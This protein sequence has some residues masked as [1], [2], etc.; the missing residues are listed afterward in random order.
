MHLAIAD[1]SPLRDVTFAGSLGVSRNVFS[2]PVTRD[3]GGCYSIPSSHPLLCD[4]DETREA[5]IKDFVHAR[6]V[7]LVGLAGPE[8]FD[9]PPSTDLNYS[10]KGA[11][12][13]ISMAVPYHVGAIYD[14]LAKR[15][16]APHNLD[17]FLKYQRI[18]RLEKDL[19][20]FLVERGFRARPLPMSCDYR[21][22]PVR[23]FAQARL[24]AAPGRDS[25]G[26]RR[27]WLVGQRQDEGIRCRRPPGWSDHRRGAGERP[28]HSHQLLHRWRLC[29]VQALRHVL[30]SPHVRRQRGR[31][32]LPQ[33][34]SA[35]ARPPPQHRLLQYFLL[36]AAQPERGPQV[37]QLGTALDRGVGG[38]PA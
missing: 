37:Q 21:R 18:M 20:D 16:P 36:R 5:D 14:F 23:L 15:S 38:A 19:G 28:A 8:R 34:R 7:E 9:G 35:P 2:S 12:S 3:P 13:V 24:L 4:V 17:Q 31:V 27:P 10:M 26:H 11:K 6:G 30:P 33:R 32:H 25:R 22:A 29:E 1:A